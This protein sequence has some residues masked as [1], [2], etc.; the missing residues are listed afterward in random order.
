MWKGSEA[1]KRATKKLKKSY[2]D[3]KLCIA[4][5]LPNERWPKYLCKLCQRRV[6]LNRRIKDVEKFLLHYKELLPQLRAERTAIKKQIEA[7]RYAK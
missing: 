7:N 2:Y 5:V 1:E 4:C 3:R 6:Y